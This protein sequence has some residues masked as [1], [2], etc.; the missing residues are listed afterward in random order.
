MMQLF[1]GLLIAGVVSCV[2]VS[3][4]AA[5]SLSSL[6]ARLLRWYYNDPAAVEVLRKFEER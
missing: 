5:E 1:A 6:I 3:W 4:L 2:L